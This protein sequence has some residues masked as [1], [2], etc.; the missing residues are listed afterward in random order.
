M[1]RVPVRAILQTLGEM[2]P[3]VGTALNFTTPFELLVAT[4]LS[5]QCTDKLVNTVT[6]GVFAAYPTPE[7]MAAATAEDIEPL[8]NRCGLY[9]NKAKNLAAAARVIV[10]RHQGQIPCTMEDLLDLPGVGRK[11]ANVVL[12]NAFG[13]PGI[14]VDTHVF[15]VANRLGLARGKTPEQV[16][17]QLQRRIPRADW[18][19]THHRLIWHGRLVCQARRPKCEECRLLPYCPEGRRRMAQTHTGA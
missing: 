16:E 15:R 4:V 10:E 18:G 9:R 17:A 19:I 7:A 14:A 2:Y 5:A 3:N 8:I 6:P 11:T 1:P 12:S 13:V